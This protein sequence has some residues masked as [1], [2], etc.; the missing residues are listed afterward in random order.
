MCTQAGYD[1]L[2]DGLLLCPETSRTKR[3]FIKRKPGR[4]AFEQS[5]VDVDVGVGVA[6]VAEVE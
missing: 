6:Q 3:K 2:F 5:V 4:L 1:L